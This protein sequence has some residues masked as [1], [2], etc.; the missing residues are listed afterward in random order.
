MTIQFYCRCKWDQNFIILVKIRVKWRLLTTLPFLE[1]KSISSAEALYRTSALAAMHI[2][3]IETVQFSITVKVNVP[4]THFWRKGGHQHRRHGCSLCDG[5]TVF[6][7]TVACQSLYFRFRG[8]FGLFDLP[9]ISSLG[10]TRFLLTSLPSTLTSYERYPQFCK[11]LPFLY[12]CSFSRPSGLTLT[13]SP[14][15]NSVRSLAVW[16]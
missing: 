5:L 14:G 10:W 15:F 13:V 6:S 9:W 7:T 12:S 11:T 8:S 4:L 2:D 16:S 3:C 1:S